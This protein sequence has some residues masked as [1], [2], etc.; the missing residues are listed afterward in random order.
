MKNAF[1]Y[2]QTC[3]VLVQQ[4]LSGTLKLKSF[5]QDESTH[6]PSIGLAIPETDFEIEYFNFSSSNKKLQK[7]KQPIH[8]RSE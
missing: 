7:N 8:L 2:V 6:M 1:K 4:F 5:E 3:L